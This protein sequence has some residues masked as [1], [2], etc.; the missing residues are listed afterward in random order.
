MLDQ[1]VDTMA[2]AM[3]SFTLD[4]VEQHLQDFGKAD[5]ADSLQ[6]LQIDSGFHMAALSGGFDTPEG[7][8]EQKLDHSTGKPE[9]P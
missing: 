5:L 3:A 8:I 9:A 6:K 7:F 2:L 4:Q 1:T